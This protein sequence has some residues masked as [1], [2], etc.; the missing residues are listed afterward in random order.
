MTN[1]FA[2]DVAIETLERAIAQGVSFIP[3][4]TEPLF[5]T[6][7]KKTFLLFKSLEGLPQLN[8]KDIVFTYAKIFGE[9]FPLMN[10]F[11]KSDLYLVSELIRL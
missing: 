9:E 1:N 11:Y 6:L 4:S 3:Y 7:K 2:T 5:L 8:Q 10:N